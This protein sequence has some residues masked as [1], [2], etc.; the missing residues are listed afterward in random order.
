[1]Y[2]HHLLKCCR[3]LEAACDDRT[4]SVSCCIAVELLES[5][6]SS[7]QAG[8]DRYRTGC[9]LD[10]QSF[11]KANSIVSLASLTSRIGKLILNM[12]SRLKKGP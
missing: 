3:N 2:K 4:F 10:F 9:Q 1:M 11:G 7:A 6:H 8:Y 5:S 12:N